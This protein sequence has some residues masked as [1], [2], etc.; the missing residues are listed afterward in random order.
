MN[1]AFLLVSSALLVGQPAS[2]APAPAMVASSC[3]QSCGCEGSGHSLRDRLRGLFSRDCSD[4]CKPAPCHTHHAHTSFFKSSCSSCNDTCCKAKVW[5]WTPK[6]REPRAC[7]PAACDDKCGHGHNILGKL[8]DRFS[9][10]SS[11]CDTG[12][13]SNGCS[14]GAPAPM[15]A[16][17]KVEPPK[18]MPAENIPVKPKA[19]PQED[20]RSEPAPVPFAVPVTPDVPSVEIVPVPAPVP[21]PRVEG[22]RRDPF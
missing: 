3:G 8:R 15:K 4:A 12:C 6:C 2:P 1:A 9:R 5:T 22:A 11:C 10:G 17:E 21:A 7:A 14:A 19:K 20:V 13:G 16:V 18:K